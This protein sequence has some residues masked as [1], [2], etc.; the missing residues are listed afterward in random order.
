MI[1]I[2]VIIC[3]DAK[4]FIK[5]SPS[6]ISEFDAAGGQ[7]KKY[8]SDKTKFVASICKPS[9][10]LIDELK[11]LPYIIL[12]DYGSMRGTKGE[13]GGYK[14]P[15]IEV[16]PA[17]LIKTTE[18]DSLTDKYV[19]VEKMEA[20][21]DKVIIDPIYPNPQAPSP[22]GLSARALYIEIVGHDKPF[23]HF[24]GISMDNLL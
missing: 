8:S 20:Q 17:K 19:P 6:L 10:R 3:T 11:K 7:W 1:P 14:E 22:E 18:Y 15:R 5:N 24:S 13:V 9:K 23:L 4:S 2:S 21:P 12:T 16:Q